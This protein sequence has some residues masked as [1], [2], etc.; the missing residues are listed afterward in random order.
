MMRNAQRSNSLSSSRFCLPV[1]RGQ[2]CTSWSSLLPRRSLPAALGGFALAV[3]DGR[4]V[5]GADRALQDWPGERGHHSQDL[6][7]QIR[8]AGA[9]VQPR[10]LPQVPVDPAAALGAVARDAR[11]DAGVR[12]EASQVPQAREVRPALVLRLAPGDGVLRPPGGE[13]AAP[14]RGGLGG[15]RLRGLHGL[16]S[17]DLDLAG[18]PLL[19]PAAL[20]Q[21]VLPEV[22]ASPPGPLEVQGGVPHVPGAAPAG[23]GAV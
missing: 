19:V 10:A 13:A 16:R 18:Q 11:H 9:P 23:S 7:Q 15:L 6:V 3:R 2:P 21:G 8:L 20:D 5:A 14:P 1:L 4:N 22:Q 12:L 17:L